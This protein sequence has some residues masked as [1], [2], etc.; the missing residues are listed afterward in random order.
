MRVVLVYSGL[1]RFFCARARLSP[2]PLSRSP[3]RALCLCCAA[4]VFCYTLWQLLL[5]Q[6]VYRMHIHIII[7]NNVSLASAVLQSVEPFVRVSA[8][9]FMIQ[10][11]AYSLAHKK[12]HVQTTRDIRNAES[13]CAHRDIYICMCNERAALTYTQ[14][15]H[16][17]CARC[18]IAFFRV[19]YR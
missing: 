16:T 19:P 14:H 6:Y 10:L 12:P 15:A 7:I 13:F 3:G 11:L 1:R 9:Q 18:I 8:R 2:P 17:L 4:L 5:L